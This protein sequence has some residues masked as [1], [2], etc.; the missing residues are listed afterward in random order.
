MEKDIRV[1]GTDIT[2]VERIGAHSHIRGLGLAADLTPKVNSEGMVGQLGARR[3]LGV[4]KKLIQNGQIAGRGIL[5]AGQPGTGKTALAMGL[6]QSLGEDVPF[7]FI[8]GSEIFSLEMSKT[9]ALTQSLR[10]A[11][12]V[13]IREET[14]IIEG[15]VV[16]IQVERA[17][18][19]TG[20]KIGKLT[21]KTTDMDTIYDLGQKMIDALT[22]EKVQAGDIIQIDKASGKVTKLGRSHTRISD[23]EVMPPGITFVNCPEGELQ[24]RK[25][26]VHKVSLH[27]VDV[28]NSRAQG[29]LALFTGDAGEIKSEIRDQINTKISEW[30]EEG[31]AEIIPGVLFIDEVHMLDIE[32]FSFLNRAMENDMAPIVVMASNRGISTIRGTNYKGPHGIPLDLLDRLL[33]V[34][35]VPYTLEEIH[36]ILQTRCNEEGV[37]IDEKALAVLTKIGEETSLRYAIHLIITADLIS[38]KR[39]GK[40]IEVEDIKRAYTLFVDKKRS[41]AHLQEYQDQY[42]FNEPNPDN[43]VKME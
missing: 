18:S 1:S 8:S 28:I 21:M 16:E 24:Q 43:D 27:E 41:I 13:R 10:K 12:G 30:K 14:E 31:K 37:D 23:Y 11:I 29:F 22:K 42:L 4:I 32:C 15:E 26:V 34:N 3:A 6:A 40:Q 39:A 36:Q 38:K 9:E 20:N 2:K 17:A 5:I 7:V 33:I 19:G 35:T 25:D